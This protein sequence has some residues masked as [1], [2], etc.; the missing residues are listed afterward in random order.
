VGGEIGDEEGLCDEKTCMKKRRYVA[1]LDL[2]T[3]SDVPP[4]NVLT[5]WD[6]NYTLKCTSDANNV[7]LFI[8]S[9]LDRLST[10]AG[11]PNIR[12]HDVLLRVCV[13]ILDLMRQTE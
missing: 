13:G 1:V 11:W 12:S 2:T 7:W 3:G 6:Y 10:P 5:S 4:P 8:G 9:S